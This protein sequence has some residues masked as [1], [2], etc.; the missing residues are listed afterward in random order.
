M[1]RFKSNN[2]HFL[3]HLFQEKDKEKKK[4]VDAS[5]K[6]I[7]RINASE[8]PFILLGCFGSLIN[9]GVM[10]AFAII[11]AEII[12]VSAVLFHQ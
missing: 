10:P 5:L 3:P 2:V 12:G 9:G 7:L 1:G 11:F 6:R 4:E 8:W